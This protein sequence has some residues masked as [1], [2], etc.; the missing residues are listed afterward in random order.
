[1]PVEVHQQPLSNL[2]ESIMS[3]LKSFGFLLGSTAMASA[4]AQAVPSAPAA[5]ATTVV[6]VHG[7]F[8]DSSSWSAVVPRLQA[9][10]LRVVSVAN[11]LRT[12][13]GDADYLGKLVDSVPGPVVL[14]GH[15]YGGAVISNAATGRKN[16]KSL[17]YV[18]AFVPDAGETALSLA[19]KFPG[20]TLGEAL[21]KPVLLQDGGKDLYIQQDK[22]HQQF[23]ADVPAAAGALMAA[24]QR[25]IAEAALTQA[26]G[27]PAWKQIP[28]WSIYGTADKNIPPAAMKFMSQRANARKVTEIK[29]AS[30]VVMVSHPEEVAA[31]IVEAATVD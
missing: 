9:K 14:V 28:S 16:V 15:S 20:G 4:I 22:F 19:G 11:P 31:M 26:S 12:L 8:A 25:P 17:V 1:M 5:Q 29:G 3:L 6:L 27:T 30:H 2:L 23:A 21:A 10:G 13:I 18:A 24:T 7:A